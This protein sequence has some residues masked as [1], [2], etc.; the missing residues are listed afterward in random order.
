MVSIRCDMNVITSII[1][2]IASKVLG[3]TV[4]MSCDI[5]NRI[6]VLLLN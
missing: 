6:V 4:S 2:L 3:E 5:A 1:I